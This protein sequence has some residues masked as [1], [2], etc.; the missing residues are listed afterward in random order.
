MGKKMFVG[1]LPYEVTESQLSEMFSACGQVVSAKVI[2]D[3]H[4]P[5]Q[6]LRIRGDGQ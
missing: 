6:G 5:L 3:R 2:K 4:R 1:G